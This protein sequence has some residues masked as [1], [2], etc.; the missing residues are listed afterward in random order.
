M[1]PLKFIIALYVAIEHSNGSINFVDALTKST[2]QKK[3]K[4]PRQ[5]FK[6]L[7]KLLN[8]YDEGVIDD[9]VEKYES[10]NKITIPDNWTWADIEKLLTKEEDLPPEVQS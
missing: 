2:L 7:I 10:L 9:L 4:N 1:T 8:M 6:E 5:Y 3:N